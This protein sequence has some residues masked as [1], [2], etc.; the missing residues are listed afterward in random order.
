MNIYKTQH[1]GGVTMAVIVTLMSGC[2]LIT[3]P[4]T[5]P[6]PAAIQQGGQMLNGAN[7]TDKVKKE[8][9]A[10]CGSASIAKGKEVRLTNAKREAVMTLG[11]AAAAA[12]GGAAIGALSGGYSPIGYP[13]G[14]YGY[15]SNAGPGAAIGGAVGA[16]GGAVG[17]QFMNNDPQ[18]ACDNEYITCITSY[19]QQ[20]CVQPTQAQAQEPEQRTV[21]VERPVVRSRSAMHRRKTV[22]TTEEWRQ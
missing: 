20:Q 11:A 3:P 5:G 6:G 7:C 17:S 22:E 15:T 2:A 12:G 4:P 19:V 9:F 16:V 18:G 8:A 1:L 21:Y 13:Y 14:G 10:V